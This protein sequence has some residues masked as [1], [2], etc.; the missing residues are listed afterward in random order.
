[1]LQLLDQITNLEDELNATLEEQ[2]S[3]QRYRLKVGV[4]CWNKA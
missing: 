1:M 3:R 2:Q 4:S